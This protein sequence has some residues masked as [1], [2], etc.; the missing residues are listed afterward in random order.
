MMKMN[1]AP[2]T[3]PQHCQYV[4]RYPYIKQPIQMTSAMMVNFHKYTRGIEMNCSVLIIRSTI[5]SGLSC[6]NSKAAVSFS[7]KDFLM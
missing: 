7:M 2:I 3:T 4:T 5:P 1:S 6:R